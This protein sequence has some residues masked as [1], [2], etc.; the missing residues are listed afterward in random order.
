MSGSEGFQ[1]HKR[2]RFPTPEEVERAEKAAEARL[3]ELSKPTG[4]EF[5]AWMGDRTLLPKRP[6]S[7]Q[8]P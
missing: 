5:P 3:R 2:R 6:P 8:Q 4:R 1:Q 7:R